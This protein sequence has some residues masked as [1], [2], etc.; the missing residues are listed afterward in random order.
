MEYQL[1]LQLTM[2]VGYF[3][4]SFSVS[5]MWPVCSQGEAEEDAHLSSRVPIGLHFLLLRSQLFFLFSTCDVCQLQAQHQTQRQSIPQASTPAPAG[6]SG[7]ILMRNPFFHITHSAHAF[8]VKPQLIL[9][10]TASECCKKAAMFMIPLS[11]RGKKR[12]E[13]VTLNLLLGFFP[14]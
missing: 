14:S 1:L 7:F 6:V 2:L 11:Q 9:L 12:H 13:C 4:A 8:L 5:L 10:V 3:C